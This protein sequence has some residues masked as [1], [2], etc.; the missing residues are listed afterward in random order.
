MPIYKAPV[1]DVQFLFQRPFSRSTAT[2]ICPALPMP[3]PMSARPSWARAAKLSEEVLQPLNRVWLISRAASVTTDG[4]V[5][6][7]KGFKGSLQGRSGRG[8]AWARGCRRPTEYGGAGVAGHAEPGGQRIPDSRR[9]MAIFRCM[10][11]LT[12]GATGRASSSTARRTR[13]RPMC[14][15]WWRASGPAR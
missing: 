13:R 7:P 10:A 11:A 5:T 8:A 14:R 3:P 6:T 9:N 15:K 4:R 1:E 12:M 2:T